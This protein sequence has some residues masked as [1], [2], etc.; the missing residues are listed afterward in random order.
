MFDKA[1][2]VSSAHFADRQE[3]THRVLL[4]VDWRATVVN[5]P[6]IDPAW[7]TQARPRGSIAV[8]TTHLEAV[9]QGLSSGCQVIAIFEDDVLLRDDTNEILA[10][11]RSDLPPSWELLYLGAAFSRA[12]EPFTDHLLRVRDAGHFHAYLLSQSGMKRMVDHLERWLARPEGHFDWIF[13][14]N[15]FIVNP[16]AAIQR[17]GYSSTDGTF[18]DRET[19]DYFTYFPKDEFMRH[20]KVR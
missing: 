16:I 4:A 7:L 8:A 17:S 14:W 3:D 5:G 20:L 11:G 9:R 2:I 1:C 19:R 10:Q 6:N 15:A 12:P 13:G 18:I